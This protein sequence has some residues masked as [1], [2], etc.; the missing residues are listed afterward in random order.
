MPIDELLH[1]VQTPEALASLEVLVASCHK[2]RCSCTERQDHCC[3]DSPVCTTIQIIM[4]H[5]ISMQ[6]ALA[7][8]DLTQSEFSNVLD[9][10]H[11]VARD[12]NV[13]VRMTVLHTFLY[14]AI[15]QC[16]AVWIG[17]RPL[18]C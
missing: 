10:L 18:L 14:C 17:M 4:T 15:G 3:V 16:I 13:K 1:D 9:T 12:V 8:E 7:Q 5:C 2:L 11:H 6:E